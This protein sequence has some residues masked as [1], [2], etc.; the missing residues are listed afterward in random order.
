MRTHARRPAPL[1]LWTERAL[2]LTGAAALAWCALVLGDAM[3]AQWS[4][5]RSLALASAPASPGATALPEPLRLPMLVVPEPSQ[6]GATTPADGAERSAAIAEL[7]IPRIHLAAAVLHGTDERTLRRGPGHLEHTPYPGERG[8]VVIAGHR[9]TFFLPLRHIGPGD[10]IYL[11][12]PGGRFHYRVTMIRVVGAEDVSVLASS[13]ERTLTLVTCYPFWVL[14][15]APDRFV[16]TAEAVEAEQPSPDEQEVHD[17]IDRFQAVYNLQLLRGGDV[18]ESVPLSLTSCRVTVN[19]GTATADCAG[20][21]E[22]RTF[23]L[24]RREGAWAIRSVSRR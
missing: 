14:G 13:G 22:S 18:G 9:D 24:E 23:L 12:T 6:D 17:E 1:R 11:A 15:P 4:A 16:V 5:R 21:G 19:A 2:S 3:M 7:S 8:N 20:A 10:D